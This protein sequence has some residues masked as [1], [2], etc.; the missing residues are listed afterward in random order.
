[1]IADMN[2]VF[3]I[4][5]CQNPNLPIKIKFTESCRKRAISLNLYYTVIL[6]QME[7]MVKLCSLMR[8]TV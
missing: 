1:M 5:D 7:L 6:K 2:W 3:E 8:S 4:G